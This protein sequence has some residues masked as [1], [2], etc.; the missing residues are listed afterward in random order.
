VELGQ[1]NS[2]EL[3]EQSLPFNKK[4]CLINLPFDRTLIEVSSPVG[5]V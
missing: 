5:K 1:G 2:A 4:L 3:F